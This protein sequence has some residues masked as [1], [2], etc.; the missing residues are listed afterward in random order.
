M[1]ADRTAQNRKT[2]IRKRQ[3]A[4]TKSDQASIATQRRVPKAISNA[5]SV[6]KETLMQLLLL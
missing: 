4:V 6:Y 1:H 5:G 3:F 2:D